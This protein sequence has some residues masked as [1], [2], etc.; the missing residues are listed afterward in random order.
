MLKVMFGKTIGST[1]LCM[2]DLVRRL[3]FISPND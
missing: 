2:P 3:V 1:I